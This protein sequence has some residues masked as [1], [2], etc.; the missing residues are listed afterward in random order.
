MGVGWIVCR[1]TPLFNSNKKFMPKFEQMPMP[2]GEK[3]G[4]GE[5]K[6]EGEEKE[7]EEAKK[8]VKPFLKKVECRTNFT[9]QCG[10]EFKKGEMINLVLTESDIRE[11]L[12]HNP[13][14][15]PIP[16]RLCEDCLDAKLVRESE[17][18]E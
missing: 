13:N 5:E 1:T 7:K 9:C 6:I 4:E 15:R 16:S 17:E 3:F 8:E 12:K 2:E 18:R 11:Q 14:G 10:K